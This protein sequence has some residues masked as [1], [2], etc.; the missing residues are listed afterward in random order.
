MTNIRTSFPVLIIDF[1]G[2]KSMFFLC[3]IFMQIVSLVYFVTLET[4][5]PPPPPTILEPQTRST[6]MAT[7][8]HTFNYD[9]FGLAC[10]G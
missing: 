6:E 7:F 3:R 4:P 5:P 2:P 9:I 1:Y 10:C 8:L